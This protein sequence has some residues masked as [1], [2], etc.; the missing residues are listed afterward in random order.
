MRK[1]TEENCKE[2]FYSLVMEANAHGSYWIFEKLM[3]I[4]G[5]MYLWGSDEFLEL[6]QEADK[7][8][9][10]KMDVL[11]VAWKVVSKD[12]LMDKYKPVHKN[13]FYHHATI[14]Y[15]KQD[16]DGRER[17]VEQIKITGRLTTDKVDVLL[18]DCESYNEHPHIT[19]STAEGV[20]PVESNSEIS[21]HIR[22]IV[23]V[24]D[25]VVCMFKNVLK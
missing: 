3:L 20:A 22:E 14:R 6:V 23:P 9:N 11:Y 16:Y 12:L 18:V 17:S 10:F 13:I 24:S 19:L 5:K 1:F 7:Y 25:F 8:L 4:T 2:L 15:G 21:K